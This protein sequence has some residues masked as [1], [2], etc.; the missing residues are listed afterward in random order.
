MSLDPPKKKK[1]KADKV[2]EVEEQIER[3]LTE[4]EVAAM[5]EAVR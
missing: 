1:K 4:A 5:N 2:E 3:D